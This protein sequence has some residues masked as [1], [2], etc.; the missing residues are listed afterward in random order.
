MDVRFS[1]GEEG[2]HSMLVVV[3]SFRI[4]EVCMFMKDS[5]DLLVSSFGDVKY[6]MGNTNIGFSEQVSRR[7]KNTDIR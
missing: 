2:L 5:K 1:N 6:R 3:F 7:Y 4:Y